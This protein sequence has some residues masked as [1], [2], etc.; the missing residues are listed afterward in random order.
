M[1]LKEQ[2]DLL[3][4]QVSGQY[5]PIFK[6]PADKSKGEVFPTIWYGSD[7]VVTGIQHLM[8]S[9]MVLIAESPLLK[10]VCFHQFRNCLTYIEIDNRW[11]GPT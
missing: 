5:T 7:I 6:R 11:Q 1:R 2:E 8:I 4:Q 9:K 3:G 10:Y